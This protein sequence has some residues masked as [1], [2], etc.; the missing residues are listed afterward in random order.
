MKTR[1]T[2]ILLGLAAALFAFIFFYEKNQ[3]TT[4]DAAAMNYSVALFNPEI[5]D[6]IQI[7][8]NE[9]QIKLHS[10]DGVWQ[11]DAPVAD[12]AD[13]KAVAILL[14][15]A[16]TLPNQSTITASDNDFNVANSNIRLKLS[17]KGAPPEMYFGKDS[18]VEGKIYMRL[19]GS[20]TVYV[21]RSLIKTLVMKKADDYRDHR[22]TD[23]NLPQVNRILLKTPAGE[24]ELLKN[25]EQ[26]EFNKPIKARADEQKVTKLIARIVGAHVEKFIPEKEANAAATGLAEPRGTFTISTEGNEKPYVI[27]IGQPD[28]DNVYTRLSTR[29]SVFLLSSTVAQALETLPND[30]RDTHLIPLNLDTVDRITIE[31]AGRPKIVLAR[32]L[33]DWMIKSDG[34]LPANRTEVNRFAAAVQKQQVSAFV[35]DVASDLAKYGL[36]Q[37]RLK[38]TFSS[39]ASE[40]TSETE[41]GEHPLGT[42][43]FGAVEGDHVYAMIEGEPFVV[44]IQKSLLNNIFTDPAQWRDLSVFKFKPAEIVSIELEREGRPG[45]AFAR[46][47][48]G[49]WKLSKGEGALNGVAVQSLCNTLSSLRAVRRNASTTE[50]YGFEKPALTLSF[51]TADNKSARLVVGS[52]A[53]GPMWNAMTDA[54]NGTFVLSR[55]DVEVMQADFVTK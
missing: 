4:P 53:P 31:P 36:D 41:A 1:N 8:N 9:T 19:A 35:T 32:R 39:F 3:P 24:I 43:Y 16:A 18:A 22:L 33:E 47:A 5:I 17:G 30:L 27:Q 10:V 23:I 14:S 51:R 25:R 52:L 26:W 46:A 34:D 55:P 44:A 20:D 38:V 11:M 7:N 13:L 15:V 6:G 50:G 48:G 12:R 28:G 37:P 40:N 42:L 2:L 29:D 45:V 21:T 49:E 54:A